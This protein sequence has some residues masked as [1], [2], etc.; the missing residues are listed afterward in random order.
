MCFISKRRKV[1]LDGLN[2]SQTTVN[3][4]LDVGLCEVT[5]WL[6]SPFCLGPGSCGSSGVID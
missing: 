6:S 4:L 2:R 1:Q 5:A 3:Q